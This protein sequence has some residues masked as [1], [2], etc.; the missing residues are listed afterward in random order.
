MKSHPASGHPLNFGYLRCDTCGAWRKLLAVVSAADGGVVRGVCPEGC[1]PV[2]AENT[3][4][5]MP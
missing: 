5:V 3:A 2:A 4:E 1:K